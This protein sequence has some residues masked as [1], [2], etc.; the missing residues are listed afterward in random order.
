[1]VTRRAII[2]AMWQDDCAGGGGIMARVQAEAFFRK[3]IPSTSQFRPGKEGITMMV[4]K[5]ESE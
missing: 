3:V 4:Y 5:Y 1:Q 2:S